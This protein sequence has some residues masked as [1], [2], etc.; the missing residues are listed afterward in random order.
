MSFPA[1]EFRLLTL[2]FAL[3]T[4]ATLTSPPSLRSHSSRLRHTWAFLK[5]NNLQTEPLGAYENGARDTV[6]CYVE[7][8]DGASIEVGWVDLRREGVK[9][10]FVVEVKVDGKLCVSLFLC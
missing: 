2:P 3:Y 9:E 8:V 7:A 6:S 1:P 10:A 5:L 4:H